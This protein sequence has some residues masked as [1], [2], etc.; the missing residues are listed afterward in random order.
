MTATPTWGCTP[1]PPTWACRPCPWGCARPS[2]AG[3]AGHGLA[4]AGA[5][6][7]PTASSPASWQPWTAL[8]SG[9]E[10]G[11]P[12]VAGADLAQRLLLLDDAGAR[13]AL[14]EEEILGAVARVLGLDRSRLDPGQPLNLLGVD[15][16][17]AMELRARLETALGVTVSVVDLLRGLSGADLAAGVLE[18]L[19]PVDEEVARLLEEVEQLSQEEVRELLG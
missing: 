17:M 12:E 5:S 2:A 9:A 7:P 18:Q 15:S 4:P 19:A 13:Q 8:P 14:V 6:P 10:E 16:L 3:R 1:S 11:A